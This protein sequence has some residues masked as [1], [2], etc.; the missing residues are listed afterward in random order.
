MAILLILGYNNPAINQSQTGKGELAPSPWSQD[1]DEGWVRPHRLWFSGIKAALR[2]NPSFSALSVQTAAYYLCQSG[3]YITGIELLLAS[4]A[5]THAAE[6]LAENVDQMLNMGQWE[7]LN[8]WMDRLPETILQNQ[9]RLLHASGEI[10]SASG[11]MVGA[12]K[13]FQLAKRQYFR[14]NDSAGKVNSL[15]A[16]STL[17]THLDDA[18]EVWAS[19]YK[20]LQIAQSTGLPEL[21]S[22]A[23][24]QIGILALQAGDVQHAIQRL[25]RAGELARIIGDASI[26][27]R[28]EDLQALALEHEQH[29]Q[30]RKRQQQIYMA[31]QQAEQSHLERL[32]QVIR[33]PLDQDAPDWDSL[34]WLQAPMM[35]KLG[36]A[37]LTNGH[38]LNGKESLWGK[39]SNWLQ[40]GLENGNYQKMDKYSVEGFDNLENGYPE[41]LERVTPDES[42]P[43]S[44]EITHPPEDQSESLS[45]HSS[46]PIQ[47]LEDPAAILQPEPPPSN[48]PSAIMQN[49]PLLSSESPYQ[50]SPTSSRQMEGSS[51]VV[52]CLGSFRVYQNDREITEWQ[53]LKSRSIFRYL[54]TRPET[55][56]AKDVLMDLFWP[57][58]DSEA[59][60]RNLHQ[61][62]YALRKM[63]NKE[64]LDFQ[65]IQFENGCY[66]LNP[67]LNIWVDFEEFEKHV[68]AGQHLEES[69]AIER[70]IVEYG[71]AEGL[72][73]GDFLA[74]DLYE[75]WCQSHRRY[76]W[77]YYL[78]IAL[79]LARYY[80]ECGEYA[81]A[82]ILS[83]RILYM[84]DCQEEAHRNLMICSLEQG[85]RHLALGQYRLCVQS[86]KDALNIS[87]SAETQKLYKQIVRG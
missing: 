35:L 87:P 85:Q 6:Y 51:L 41:H 50:P 60:R 23:E 68:Q 49:R 58:A 67:D 64:S 61:A 28:I 24:L 65:H 73:Q 78:F 27:K 80:L 57:D 77:Q 7:L 37:V 32:Q 59:A 8:Y 52:Y 17:A 26:I 79:R 25:E 4:K 48:P 20:A 2:T 5:F 36:G 81:A 34:G 13:Y 19:A 31:A 70:A 29:Q 62:I 3:F 9:P 71:I 53:S 75:E 83:R 44:I 74:D 1:L 21:E 86:L 45:T 42:A 11:D 66:R 69:N 10:K 55:P 46:D 14:K 30:Q 76:L 72:Y 38:M 84:D 18:G 82:S 33:L 39:L 43:H 47:P 54:L 12:N 63:L 22:S 56:I 40:R 15:L 16:L